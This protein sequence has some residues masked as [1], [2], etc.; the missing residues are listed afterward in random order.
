MITIASTRQ[1]I[2]QMEHTGCEFKNEINKFVK[3]IP[4]VV[5]I[6]LYLILYTCCR[7]LHNVLVYSL[8]FLQSV[9]GP[10]TV[11]RSPPFI[12]GF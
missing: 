11:D 1:R 6:G 3:H 7:C 12:R 5:G 2:I 9:G 10:T 8:K 4:A